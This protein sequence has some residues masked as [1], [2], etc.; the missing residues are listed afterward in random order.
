MWDNP[1]LLNRISAALFLL[2][3]LAAGAAATRAIT[4]GLFPFR[5]VTVLG[6]RH[7]ETQR[8]M[9][10]VVRSLQGGFFT[11]D[12]E[13]SRRAFEAVPW[14]RQATVRRLWPNRLVV[15][16]QEH[17]PAAAWNGQQMLDTHGELFDVRPWAGL[18]R[19]HAPAG[20]EREVARR[21]ADFQTI[22]TPEGWRIEALQVSP[23]RA[24][25]VTLR[26]RPATPAPSG[27]ASESHVAVSLELGREKLSERVRRFVLFHAA[28]VASVGEITQFDLR[29]PNGF[30]AQQAK[31]KARA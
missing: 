18:P 29:Y 7:T 15:Q 5:Q 2:A 8:A 1:R 27:A 6:A 31:G 20:M 28:A 10:G 24:W 30:A 3:G 23:R 11:L 25:R 16:V 4:E 13:A 22:L 26:E 14:V 17:I 19:I 21:L 9:T 12:L